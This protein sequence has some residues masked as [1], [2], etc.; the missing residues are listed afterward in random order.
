ML[1]DSQTRNGRRIK[2]V[3]D[4]LQQ[5]RQWLAD[6]QFEDEHGNVLQGENPTVDQIQ[7]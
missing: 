4:K 7:L 6:A 5:C 3:F 2:K 1:R